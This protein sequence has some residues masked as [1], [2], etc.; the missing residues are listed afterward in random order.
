MTCPSKL[1]SEVGRR[2]VLARQASCLAWW[3]GSIASEGKWCYHFVTQLSPHPHIDVT[4]STHNPAQIPQ[5]SRLQPFSPIGMRMINDR[6]DEE[7]D[8]KPMNAIRILPELQASLMCETV[9]QETTGN[10]L[11][12]GVVNFIRVP[13]LPVATGRFCIYNRW[14]AGVGRF[15]DITRLVTPDGTTILGQSGA[16]F[17]LRDPANH[18]SNVHVFANAELKTAGTYYVEVMVDD[19]LKLRAPLSV[20][21]APP[22]G[23]PAPTP[24]AEPQPA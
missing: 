13:Q 6:D 21:V 3:P 16:Q 12:V 15:R 24:V 22:P 10:F 8:Y 2:L 18:A 5:A 17:E 14:T 1:P 11:L 23:R 9:R 19:V 4:N 20:V 7:T